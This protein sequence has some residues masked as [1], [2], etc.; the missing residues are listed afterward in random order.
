[1]L[2]QNP[3]DILRRADRINAVTPAVLREVFQRDFPMERYTI[4]T[5]VPQETR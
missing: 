3:A 1:M 2:G 4:V 5:L